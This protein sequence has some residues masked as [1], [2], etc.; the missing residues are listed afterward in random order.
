[1]TIADKMVERRKYVKAAFAFMVTIPAVALGLLVFGI[2]PSPAA[3]IFAT[4]SATFSAIIVGHFATTPKNDGEI[5][6]PKIPGVK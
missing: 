3:T 2:D 6:E 4:A 5:I 1:M